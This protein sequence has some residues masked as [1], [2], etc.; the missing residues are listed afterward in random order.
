M[1]AIFLALKDKKTPIFAKLLAALTLAYA[2]SPID[3]IPDFIP[4]VGYFDDII[5]LPILIALTVKFIPSEFLECSRKQ[6]QKI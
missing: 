1:P 3:L 2:F 4:V 5:I 6:L